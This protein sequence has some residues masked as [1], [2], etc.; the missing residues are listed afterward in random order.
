MYFE[1]CN[2]RFNLFWNQVIKEFLT[3]DNRLRDKWAMA[4]KLTSMLPTYRK[5]MLSQY[6]GHKHD[7]SVVY[8]LS[9][10]VIAS[11]ASLV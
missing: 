7:G 4:C 6:R 11:Y 10:S 5:S 3:C 9:V 8:A 1:K 2:I